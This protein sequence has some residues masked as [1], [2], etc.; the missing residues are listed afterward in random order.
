MLD[1]DFGTYPFVTS[2]PTTAGGVCTGLGL[3]PDKIESV[4]GVVKAYTTRVGGGPFPTE[5]TDSR[6]GGEIALNAPGT[7]VGLHLQTVGGEVGVT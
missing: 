7:D 1:I 6:G 4:V 2:S 3:S 5:L